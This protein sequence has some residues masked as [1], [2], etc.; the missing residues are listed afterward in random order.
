M[1][2][3][4][5]PVFMPMLQFKSGKRNV[6]K[7]EKVDSANNDNFRQYFNYVSLNK[8][9]IDNNSRESDLCSKEFGFL[10]KHTKISFVPS[11][12]ACQTLELLCVEI[13]SQNMILTF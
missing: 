9:G 13:H 11:K 10:D 2:G 1:E 6:D 8:R 4:I 3:S 5:T 12:L 7:T